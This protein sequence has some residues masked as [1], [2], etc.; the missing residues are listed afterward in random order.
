MRQMPRRGTYRIWHFLACS[1]NSDKS[2]AKNKV[3]RS[4]LLEPYLVGDQVSPTRLKHS[5]AQTPPP[6]LPFGNPTSC[7]QPNRAARGWKGGGRG[8]GKKPV[9]G[10]TTTKSDAKN[11]LPSMFS[12]SLSPPPPPSSPSVSLH[13]FPFPTPSHPIPGSVS[14]FGRPADTGFYSRVSLIFV[15]EASIRVDVVRTLVC[16]PT[17][18]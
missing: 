9:W 4:D 6:L 13:L 16:I 11:D 7:R 12:L 2:P 5:N 14:S 8:G 15:M 1:S 17:S 10:W 3:R 18:L